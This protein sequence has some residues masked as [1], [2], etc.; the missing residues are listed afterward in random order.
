MKVF[1]SWSGELSRGVAELLN[2]WIPEVIQD[3]E[4]WIS[5]QDLEK[6]IE[7]F[8]ELS[9]QLG[10]HRFGIICLTKT[11]L[12]APWILFEAGA[13]MKGI[14]KSRVVPFLIDVHKKDVKDPLSRFNMADNSKEEILKLFKSM[15]NN[16]EK[17][18]TDSRLETAFER[19]WEDYSKKLHE[20]C[21]KQPST[22]AVERTDS[23][24]IAEVL[25]IVRGIQNNSSNPSP[26]LPLGPY[27]QNRWSIPGEIEAFGRTLAKTCGLSVAGVIARHDGTLEVYLDEATLNQQ[28]FNLFSAKLFEHTGKPALPVIISPIKTQ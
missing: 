16:G 21:Q 4:P 28:A 13:L 14:K 12:D 18:L 26:S 9:D 19:C 11:N 6:G 10:D 5:T 27:G 25:Q 2:N 22:K 8:G 20:L 23:E 24:I 3:A 15:N 17:P 7:W 1:L